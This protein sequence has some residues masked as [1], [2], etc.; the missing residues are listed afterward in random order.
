[1]S[2]LSEGDRAGAEENRQTLSRVAKVAEQYI[3]E[4]KGHSQE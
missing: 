4:S 1:M 2:A 3:L